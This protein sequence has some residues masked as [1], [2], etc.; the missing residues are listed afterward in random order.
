MGGPGTPDGRQDHWQHVY[1]TKAADE[2][3]WYQETPSASLEM[4]RAT[5]I[6]ADA[7][8][9]DV[10]G[11]AST[12]VD[13][14]IADGYRNVAVLDIAE[15]ALGRSRDRLG[16]NAAQVEWMVADVTSWTPPREFG[17]WHDRAVFHFLT[18]PED[19]RAYVETLARTVPEGG[20]VIIATFAPDGPERC[21]GLAVMRHGLDS[22]PEELGE[23]FERV[24]HRREE[25]VTPAGRRQAFLYQRFV[26]RI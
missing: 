26:R 7:H 3:S 12:L 13:R 10:G 9:L 5:G 8:I 24:Q 20:H 1:A 21:S 6:G 17:L 14:L 22:L 19:R 11:G 25:H 4:I 23:G 18:E 16:D 2:V 15:A